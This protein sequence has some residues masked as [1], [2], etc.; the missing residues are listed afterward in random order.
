M[1]VAEEGLEALPRFVLGGEV[2]GSGHGFGAVLGGEQA[3]QG[4][5]LLDV[6]GGELVAGLRRFQGAD[7]IAGAGH[8][9]A[10][11]ARVGSMPSAI[12]P[13]RRAARWSA[14]YSSSQR[15]LA[16]R[17]TSSSVSAAETCFGNSCS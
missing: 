2:A 16:L 11:Q 8:G 5:G 3:L 13:C 1:A 4:E 12:W 14:A 17:S 9:V 15:A 7:G 6:E 10:E